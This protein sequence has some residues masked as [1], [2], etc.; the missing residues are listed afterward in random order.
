MATPALVPAA[1]LAT[2]VPWPLRTSNGLWSI[3]LVLP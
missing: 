2:T 1:M 3:S